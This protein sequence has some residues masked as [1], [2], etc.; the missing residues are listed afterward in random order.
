MKK[1][2]NVVFTVRMEEA[3]CRRYKKFASKY[4]TPS[5]VARELFN[6]L[7]DNRLTIAPPETPAKTITNLWRMNN[8]TY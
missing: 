7:V 8:E 1:L 3:E 2:K 6:A 5:D 4:G